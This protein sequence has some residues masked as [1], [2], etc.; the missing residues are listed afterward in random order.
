MTTTEPEIPPE[1]EQEEQPPDTITI[2]AQEEEAPQ[3]RG[4]QQRTGAE[5]QVFSQEDIDRIRNEERNRYTKEMERAD[6]LDAELARYRQVEDDRVKAEA[7]AQRDAEKAAKKKEEEEMEL[8]DLIARK[9]AEWE[10]R[11]QEER[12]AREQALAVLD[13]E[14]RH[15]SLQTYLAQRM[16]EVGD[17]ITPE[18]RDLVAG[19]SQEEIDA[20]INLLMEKSQL[21]MT[22]VVNGYRQVNSTRPTA[23]VTAPPIGPMEASESSRT[24]TSDELKAMSPEEYA[25]V[26]EPLLRA[27]SQSRRPQR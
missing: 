3:G 21:L 25:Q 1:G 6:A 20:S 23:G 2:P 15:A 27:A 24:Y 9:D 8:R 22:N 5:P 7:K 11:L 16:A 4:R 18:L 12:Q 26:R 17:Q 13:Q 14:R 19:N 10:A